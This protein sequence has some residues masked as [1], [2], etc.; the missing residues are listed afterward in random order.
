MDEEKK[1]WL[2]AIGAIKFPE[3]ISHTYTFP[4]YIGAFNLSD[5]YI[6]ETPI[7]ELKAQYQKNKEHAKQINESRRERDGFHSNAER[8]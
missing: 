7:Q 1:E 8:F 5:R 4:G 3:P 6:N 2:K